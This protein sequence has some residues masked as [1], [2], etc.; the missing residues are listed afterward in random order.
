MKR[1]AAFFLAAACGA[2]AAAGPAAPAEDGAYEGFL[3]LA[4]CI[5]IARDRFAETNS[6]AELAQ[7]AIDGFFAA[8]DP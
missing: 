2:A 7:I 4:R 8:L 1:I 6:A 3:A 5:L